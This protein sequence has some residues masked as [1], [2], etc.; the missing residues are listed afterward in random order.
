MGLLL[1]ALIVAAAIYASL[2]YQ[3][4]CSCLYC[5]FSSAWIEFSVLQALPLP[6]LDKLS[7]TLRSKLFADSGWS[8]IAVTLTV[9]SHKTVSLLALFL[10][11]LGLRNL[12]K[13][14]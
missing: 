12:F 10:M 11:G 7:D 6:G 2:S 8:S 9:I 3:A 1:I 14:K 5:E 13:L 4:N